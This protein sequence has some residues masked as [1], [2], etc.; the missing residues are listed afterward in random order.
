MAESSAPLPNADDNALI[1]GHNYDGIKEYD[2]PMPGWWIWIFWITVLFSPIYVLGVHTFGFLDSYQDD[3]AQGQDELQTIRH[4]YA[5]ANP[6]AAVDAASLDAMVANP[7][8]A[9]AGAVHFAAQCA[10]CHG[11]EGQGLIGPNLTDAYWIH[12]NSNQ[13]IFDIITKG[14]LE[15]G[16]PPWEAVYSPEERAELVAYINSILGTNPPNPKAPEGQPAA[17]S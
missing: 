13:A 11:M 5:E 16:M 2:N 14:V 15:K 17:A 7:Q 10:A 1:R 12:G 8:M 4:T 9:Q 3:L 6:S